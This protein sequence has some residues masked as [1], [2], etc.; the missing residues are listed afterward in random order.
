MKVNE[1]SWDRIVRVVL[2]AV[3][4]FVGFGSTISGALGV[5]VGILGVVFVVTGLMGFCPLYA[6]FK[7]DTNKNAA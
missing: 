3:L 6:L 4:L 5:V 1:A 7:I 2:G